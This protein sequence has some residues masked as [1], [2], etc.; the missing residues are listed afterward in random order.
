[1]CLAIPMQ[2][3]ERSEWD[4]TAELRGVQRQ[5][6]LMLCPE[7]QVGEYVLVHA[8]YA[9]TTVD[10]EEARKTLELLDEIVREDIPE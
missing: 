2:L 1:M 9:I 4:G 8:G 6:S 7:A 5:V 3:I 10:V